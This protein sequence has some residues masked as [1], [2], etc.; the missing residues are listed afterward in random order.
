MGIFH[1]KKEYCVAGTKQSVLSLI[2]NNLSLIPAHQFKIAQEDTDSLVLEPVSELSLHRRL[3]PP[4]VTV[5]LAGEQDS[6]VLLVCCDMCRAYKVVYGIMCALL[7]AFEVGMIWQFAANENIA[8]D[9]YSFPFFLPVILFIALSLLLLLSFY[10]YSK[11]IFSFYR[12]LL[13]T[14]H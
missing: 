4:T 2:K 6:V 10:F 8:G 12:S 7:A 1:Y 13:K 9:F 11:K 3:A 5:Q 14:E